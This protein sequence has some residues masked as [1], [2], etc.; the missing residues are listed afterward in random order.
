MG[1][2][3][4]QSESLIEMHYISRTGSL[5]IPD[6]VTNFEWDDEEGED[7]AKKRWNE[8]PLSGR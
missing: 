4:L 3:L 8:D 7:S 6:T 1:G 5:D 2:N